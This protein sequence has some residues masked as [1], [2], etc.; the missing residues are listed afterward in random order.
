MKQMR[1][2]L[3]ISTAIPTE[4]ACDAYTIALKD[5]GCLLSKVGD[6]ANYAVGLSKKI[7]STGTNESDY[8]SVAFIDVFNEQVAN[9]CVGDLLQNL[10]ESGES[11]SYD[12]LYLRGNEPYTV[13]DGA[14]LNVS[15]Y[16][17]LPKNKSQSSPREG[18]QKVSGFPSS[19]SLLSQFKKH[20]NNI[21]S[22][23]LGV[24]NPESTGTYEGY[25][26]SNNQSEIDFNNLPFVPGFENGGYMYNST[27]DN[28]IVHMGFETA[29][30]AHDKG[31][32]HLFVH[33][34]YGYM[35]H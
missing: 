8:F 19:E 28:N 26:L 22:T 1:L 10:L 34:Q 20:S 23:I 2:Y 12:G 31:V 16:I 6:P 13:S 15:H 29:H 14:D 27:I 9:R 33:N 5:H 35:F 24:A 4:E 11:I 25:K 7:N 17:V 3:S 21:F 30:P 32:P 18:S